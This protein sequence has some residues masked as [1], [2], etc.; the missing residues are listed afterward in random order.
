VYAVLIKGYVSLALYQLD[1]RLA[2]QL[3]AADD[4]SDAAAAAAAAAAEDHSVASSTSQEVLEDAA[5]LK[6]GETPLLQFA[7][8]L[9]TGYEGNLTAQQKAALDEM[10]ELLKSK[11]VETWALLL[12]HPDGPDR[13]MLRFLRAECHGRNRDFNVAKS[14]KRLAAT[15]RFRRDVGADVLVANPPPFYDLFTSLGAELETMDR[16][17]RVVVWTRAGLISTYMDVSA[18]S[19]D[20]WIK[21]M[22]TIT[23]RRFARLRESS[24]RLGHEVSATVVIYDLSGLGLRSAKIL[25]FAQII[26]SVAS[27]H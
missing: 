23:E 7:A 26:N 1:A 5:A 3:V 4:G 12:K 18:L 24:K 14:H 21:G 17:G 2:G 15:L 11:D 20:E 6:A 25:K 9:Q 13:Y 8:R 19:N 22:V 27:V 10:R 16:E